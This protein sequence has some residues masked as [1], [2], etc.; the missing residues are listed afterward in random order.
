MNAL[1]EDWRPDFYR[2]GQIELS[3]VIPLY[4]EHDVILM[5]YQRLTAVLAG[6][7]I[8]Y[9]LV[10]VDD[11]SR[12]GTPQ[13]M[14]CL[15]KDDPAITAVF[16]SRNF[17]K[18]AALTAGIDQAVGDAAIIMDAVLKDPTE[19]IPNM[20]IRSEELREGRGGGST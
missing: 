13:A 3:V 6:L 12:D 10:L 18:E 8:A 16:L 17:G 20:L 7:D 5:M 1:A 11:G 15:A 2:P 14:S 9:E 19:L 4:N